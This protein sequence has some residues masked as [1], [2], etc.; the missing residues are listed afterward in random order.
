MLNDLFPTGTLEGGNNVVR[1]AA[2]ANNDP[3]RLVWSEHVIELRLDKTCGAS[4]ASEGIAMPTP[5][6]VFTQELDGLA[7]TVTI[8]EQD[9]AFFADIQ[10][11]EGAMDVNAVYIGDDDFSGDSV[12]LDG[13]LNMNGAQLDGAVQWDDAYH[14]SDPGLGRDG[15]DKETYLSEGDTLTV[16]LDIESLDEVDIFGVRATSTTTDAGS[17]KAVSDDPEEPEEPEDPTYSKVFFGNEYSD[18]GDP[19]GGTF[20]LA[21]EPADNPYSIPALPEGT[22]PTFE[23][24]LSY[25]T[26]D[27]IGGDVTQLEGITFYNADDEGNLHELFRIDAP[28]GGFADT[29]EVLD[30]YDDAIDDLLLNSQGSDESEVPDL[31]ALLALGGDG[32]GDFDAESDAASE[33]DVDVV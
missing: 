6:K 29:A 11:T 10:V 8:Y 24:Y 32:S 18:S 13:P 23:N 4:P 31:M 19:I 14:L 1:L 9:G 28:E 30:A 22:E 15:A 20:I 2:C 5:T 7:Y 21:E 27:E 25:F 33:D 26:S 17:I 12:S 16:A 3:R